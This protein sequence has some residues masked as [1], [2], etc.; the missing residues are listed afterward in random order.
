VSDVPKKIATNFEINSGDILLL[1][2]D[3]DAEIVRSWRMKPNGVAI[4]PIDDPSIEASI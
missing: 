3:K 2:T 4:T 1:F